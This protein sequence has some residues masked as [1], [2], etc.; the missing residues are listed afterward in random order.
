VAAGSAGVVIP[1]HI[2]PFG[3]GYAFGFRI[4]APVPPGGRAVRLPSVL[5]PSSVGPDGKM[6]AATAWRPKANGSGYVNQTCNA[7]AA[8]QKDLRITLQS[9][10][11]FAQSY[12]AWWDRKPILP[13]PRSASSLRRPK[14]NSNSVRNNHNSSFT[15]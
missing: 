2:P 10:G 12:H 13:G 11:V 9:S 4:S 6:P 5:E 3:S 7:P 8:A 15:P 14:A 1:K